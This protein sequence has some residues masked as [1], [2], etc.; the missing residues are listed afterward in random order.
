M[1]DAKDHHDAASP[2]TLRVVK[3]ALAGPVL[4]FAARELAAGLGAMLARTLPIE[5]AD[6]LRDAQLVLATGPSG[7]Q[8]EPV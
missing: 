5:P 4:E 7:A 2:A 8:T 6:E 3:P 1:S